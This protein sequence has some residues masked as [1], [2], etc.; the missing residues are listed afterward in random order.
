MAEQIDVFYSR[1]NLPPAIEN[2]R[3]PAYHKYLVYTDKAGQKSLLRAGPDRYGATSE[4]LSAPI[5]PNAT[6]SF[7][8]VRFLDGRLEEGPEY[9]THSQSL[10][11]PLL[12]GDDFSE[13]WNRMRTAFHEIE[14]MGYQYWPQGVNSNTIVDGTL[15][16]GGFKPTY[17]DGAARNSEWTAPDRAGMP[18]ISTPGFDYLPTPPNERDGGVLGSAKGRHS[19]RARPED[20]L[21]LDEEAFAQATHGPRWRRI[22]ER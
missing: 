10:G 11:E 15:S 22:W 6:S 9:E 2:F 16:R 7:G 12:S 19:D 8:P 20:L 13:E 18:T 21:E 17:R 3:G 14:G 5:Y 1:I 4:A